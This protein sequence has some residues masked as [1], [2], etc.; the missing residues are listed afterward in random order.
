VRARWP[1]AV[2]GVLAGVAV[3]AVAWQ[4]LPKPAT[5]AP[6]VAQAVVKPA[7]PKPL[8]ARPVEAPIAGGDENSALRELAGLWGAALAAGSPCDAALAV[9]LRCY[10]GK[11]GLYEL[12]VL[13]RP[14]VIM[15]HDGAATRYALLTV[16]NDTTATLVSGGITQR[17]GIGSLARDLGGEFTTLYRMPRGFRSQIVAGAQ[18]D[19][20]DWIAQ[21]LAQI[22][23]DEAPPVERPFGRRTRVLLK[24]FQ[25]SQNMKP[26]GVAGPRTY[27]RL[28]QL[29][30]VTEPRLL[31][32]T[33][34][35]R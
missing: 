22:N 21:R 6:Q 18:G 27:M 3:T 34:T 4:T 29:S 8:L 31:A 26:D 15:L 16:L 12:R 5:P 9:N 2:G 20:V 30:G 17:V 28:N 23:D 13:D 35:E 32:S 14:A 25:V 1:L 33:R 19:D 11:G 10:Q 24:S 7:A